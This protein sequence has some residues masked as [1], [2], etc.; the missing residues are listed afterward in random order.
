LN[1]VQNFAGRGSLGVIEEDGSHGIQASATGD[2]ELVDVIIVGIVTAG[3]EDNK[4]TTIGMPDLPNK[5]FISVGLEYF[6]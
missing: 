6:V 3:S 1:Q 4:V 2:G 5:G